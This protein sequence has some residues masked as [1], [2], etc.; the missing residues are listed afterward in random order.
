METW[1][2]R[3]TSSSSTPSPTP[4][5]Q[6]DETP[7]VDHAQE[8]VFNY[9]SFIN[10]YYDSTPNLISILE[11]LVVSSGENKKNLFCLLSNQL[12]IRI[13]AYVPD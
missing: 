4:P 3:P 7:R 1:S 10:H 13:L 5:Q 11:T 12:L 9:D 8:F 2:T 6:D